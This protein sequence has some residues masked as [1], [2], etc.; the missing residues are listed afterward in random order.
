MRSYRL[1]PA[2]ATHGKTQDYTVEVEPAFFV[3]QFD[4]TGA[5]DPDDA[6]PLKMRASVTIAEF[7]KAINATD[8][9]SAAR[10]TDVA[11]THPPRS[12]DRYGNVYDV[13]STPTLEDA[14]F[15]AQ[16]PARR[17]R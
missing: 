1:P 14:G 11:K 9:T 3:E 5:C 12:K 6:N 13:S 4:C 7:A 16:P 8:V 15:D 2:R 10:H 17:I